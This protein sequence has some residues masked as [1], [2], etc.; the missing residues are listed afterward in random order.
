MKNLILLSI[1]LLSFVSCKKDYCVEL[2]DQTG[3]PCCIKCFRNEQQSQKFF[4]ENAGSD[5]C[6]LC[7]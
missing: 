6:Q 4:I 2:T 5:Y 1:V 7:D 3:S